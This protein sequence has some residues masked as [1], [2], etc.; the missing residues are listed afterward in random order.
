M[1]K[2]PI[3]IGVFDAIDRGR[4]DFRQPLIYTDSLLYE[5]DDILGSFKDSSQIAL[6]R[7]TLLSLTTSDNTASLWLQSLAG[8]GVAI[9]QWL[10]DHG[11]DSTRVN[12]RT[13]GREENRARYGW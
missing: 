4:L 6:S 7:L 1:I 9:N 11:F 13:P 2:V 5:G 3:L 8:T 10:A 12:S